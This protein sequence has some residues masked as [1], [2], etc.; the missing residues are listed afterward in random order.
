MGKV[1]Q[2]VSK[3]CRQGVVVGGMREEVFLCHTRGKG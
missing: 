1:G 3:V 2:W